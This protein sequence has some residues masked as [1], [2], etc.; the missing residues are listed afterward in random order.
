[1]RT[2]GSG[3]AVWGLY[4]VLDGV[5]LGSG[6]T[7]MACAAL[8]RFGRRRDGEAV[9]R[10]AM[11][12]AI[13]CFLAAGLSVMA[14]Q[15]RPLAALS[16]LARLCRPQ[17]P[18]FTTF[19]TFGAIG[20]LGSL[21]HCV[22][23]RRPD[24]A[25]YAK[26]PSFWRGLQRLLAAGY[27][28]TPAQRYRRE[29]ASFWMS[30]FFLVTLMAPLVALAMMFVARAARPPL[31]IAME[32]G[33]F[34][35]FSI[36]GGL[37]LLAI[38]AALVSRLAGT[39]SGLGV[40]GFARLGRVFLA[41]TS[42]AMLCALAAEIAGVESSEVAASAHARALL[43]EAYGYLFWSELGLLFIA[44]LALGRAA[45][46]RR[47]QGR[48]TVFAAILVEI[49]V[50][51]QRYLQLVAWQTHGLSLP[52]R[53][54]VYVPTWIECAVGLG[55]VA[56]SILMLLPAVRLIPF[57]PLIFEPGPAPRVESARARGLITFAWIGIGVVLT[58]FGLALSARVGTEPYLDPILTGSPVV[59][60]AGLVMLATAG[61]VYELLP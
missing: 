56:F 42:V 9:A 19:T 2:I 10:I 32:V 24:L 41:A 6:V 33:S 49:A 3:G 34:L 46:R 39:E 45:W 12:V 40:S 58:V 18:I 8:A 44:T 43:G 35:A 13:V 4:I 52:Y 1:M 16:N 61:A 50:F 38:S 53:P 51:L 5:F 25:E 60:I 15:G 14:D 54:G 47:L 21:V 59:F 23:A 28:G 48:A 20:I 37:G 26:R 7:V 36:A 30:L 57:R 29:K 11:P 55:I 17:S 22:L 31:L 27:L